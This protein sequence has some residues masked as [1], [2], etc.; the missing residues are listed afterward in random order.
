MKRTVRVF[1]GG[2]A[3][4]AGLL[5]LAGCGGGLPDVD[6]GVEQKILLYGNGAE[7]KGLDPHLVTGVT[8]NKIISALFEGLINYHLTDDTLPE[9]GVAERWEANEDASVWTFFLRPDAVWNNGDPVT[10]GDFVY[11][12]RRMLTPELGAEY[13]QMLFIVDNAQAY[14]EG[15]VTDFGE[16]GVEALDERTLRLTLVGPTPYFINMLKHYSW[17][18]VHPGAIAAHGGMLDLSGRWTRPGNIVTNGPFELAEWK[19]HQF[20]RVTKSASYWDAATTRLNGILFFPIEDDN[21]ERRMF[22]SGRLHYTSTV[23]TNDIPNLRATRPEIIH[24][25]PYLGTY[26]FRVN[27]TRPPLDNP[28]LRAALAWSINRREIVERVTLGDQIP[29]TAMVPHM[30]SNYPGKDYVGYDL[31]KARALLAEAGYPNGE[32]LPSFEL[33]YNTSD[34]HRKIAEALAAMW[35]RELG[36]EVRLL[37]KEWKVY[38]DDQSNLNFDL[39]RSGWIGDYPDPITFL[40]LFTTGNGNNDTGWSNPAYD[41]LIQRAFR[42]RTEAE[43]LAILREAEDILMAELPIIPLYWYTRIYLKDPRVKHWYPKV[44]DNRPWKYID[45]AAE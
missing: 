39:S 45:L 29:A 41:A 37:N 17:F 38:L 31:E 15:E 9:P 23:P 33:L 7:P 4:L 11:S 35:R 26:F 19:P 21:T 27:V 2:F 1:L 22:E 44:L 20:I 30:L 3:G 43:H 18:P 14:Y 42:S 12:Y 8:E 24:L 40:E 10:A 16:V 13:A 34:G 6:E 25:D 28:K 36:I 5:W 32:G